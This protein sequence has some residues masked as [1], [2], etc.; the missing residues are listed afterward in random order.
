ENLKYG[1]HT[2]RA[3]LVT[4]AHTSLIPQSVSTVSFTSQPPTSPISPLDLPIFQLSVFSVI[5][6]VI[7]LY[8][9]TYHI[10]PGLHPKPKQKSKHTK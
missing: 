1:P 6:I 8:F 9:I 3:E 7:A 10:K 5:L 2:L 4:N